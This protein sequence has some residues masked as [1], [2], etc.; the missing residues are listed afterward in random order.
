MTVR[1]NV[2]LTVEVPTREAAKRYRTQF[3]S[4]HNGMLYWARVLDLAIEEADDEEQ[5]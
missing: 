3:M 1:L 2:L 5:L 4:T